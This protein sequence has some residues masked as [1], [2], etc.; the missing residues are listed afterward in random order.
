MKAVTTI[1]GLMLLASLLPAQE[2][3]PSMYVHKE[4][5]T[6][7]DVRPNEVVPVRFSYTNLGKKA[8]HIEKALTSCG[9]LSY[10]LSGE[11]LE[12]GKDGFID[13]Q[14]KAPSVKGHSEY[15]ITLITDDPMKQEVFLTLTVK[16]VPEVFCE[17][18]CLEV[19]WPVKADWVGEI[20]VTFKNPCSI[21]GLKASCDS[22]K[23]SVAKADEKGATIR[24]SVVD[25]KEYVN[26]YNLVVETTSK[27]QP[28]INFPVYFKRAQEW[29]FGKD[30]RKFDFFT[31]NQTITKHISMA[32]QDGG[33]FHIDKIEPSNKFFSVKILKNDSAACE[34]D[35]TLNATGIIKGSC[36][37]YLTIFTNRG[38]TRLAIPCTARSH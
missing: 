13:L 26:S 9:C 22:L 21:T 34:F 6:L 31:G 24:L 11:I 17:P 4:H 3:L 19:D 32:H 10:I 29:L 36:D 33:V 12:P 2:T 18:I 5:I 27:E 15:R 20:K 16:V 14:Y 38:T 28:S 1:F 7:E 30:P 37:G 25:A 23:A 35:L 8:L